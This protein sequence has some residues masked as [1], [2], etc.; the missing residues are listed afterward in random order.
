MK[1]P[2]RAAGALLLTL[3][4]ACQV[5]A[6]TTKIVEPRVREVVSWLADDA[7]RGRATGSPELAEAGDW[8]AA[9]FAAAGLRQVNEGSWFHEFSVPGL[10]LDS[11]AVEVTLRL[12]EG[13][14]APEQSVVLRGGFDVRQ[15]LPSEAV[16]GDEEVTVATSVDAVLQRLIGSGS[17]RRPI[18]IE[19]DEQHPFWLAAAGSH[20]VASQRR[21]A[22][23]PVLLVRKGALPALKG[24]P[25]AAVWSADW[26]VGTPVRAD[27]GQRNVMALLPAREGSDRADEYLVVSAHYDHIGING[28]E[29][30][31]RINNGADDDASGTTAVVVLAEAL[32]KAQPRRNVLFVCFA[33]EE[34]GLLGSKAFCEKPPVP[35]ER[36]VADLN[37]EMIGRPEEGRQGM[38]WITGADYSDFAAIAE[39]ALGKADVGVVEFPLAMKLFAQSDNWSFVGKGVVAHSLSAGSLHE[40]YHRP[41]DEV[42][43]LDLAHMTRI[44]RGLYDLTLALA[45]RDDP[46]R[47]N[48]AGEKMLQKRAG[49]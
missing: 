35:I 47:W 14:A 1:N 28:W 42:A 5:R 40:D 46:P 11:D 23:R 8:L 36:I 17:A 20:E 25:R 2:S 39:A 38:A 13:D 6:Q 16:S 30:G 4:I 21:R 41:S 9:R 22:S 49:R 26:K 32:A 24:N 12:R 45:E 44:V 48:E 10:R 43:K 33:A 37:I 29:T 27:I 7:R 3:S 18:L 15:M 34:S 19:V 31:D